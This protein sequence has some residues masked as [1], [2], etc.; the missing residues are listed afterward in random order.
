MS[1]ILYLF[2][3]SNLLTELRR[4]N[5]FPLRFIDDINILTFSRFTEHNCRVLEGAN[6]TCEKW[7][8]THGS[9][10][11]PDKYHLIH[12]SRKP[13]VRA[14]IRC[15]RGNALAYFYKKTKLR[16]KG[17]KVKRSERSLINTRRYA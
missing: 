2:F 8:A 12:F 15:T 14:C 11:S 3:A 9:A 17:R 5:V 10:F 7:T 6:R 1:P 16:R 4:G 13:R